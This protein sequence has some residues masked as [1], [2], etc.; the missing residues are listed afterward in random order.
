LRSQTE[1]SHRFKWPDDNAEYWRSHLIE[2]SER[3]TRILIDYHKLNWRVL[4]IWE[5]TLVGKKKLDTKALILKISD[6][7]EQDTS[8]GI[9]GEK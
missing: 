2:N 9:I 4:T 3:D 7:L 8:Q 6:F 5:C 1:S